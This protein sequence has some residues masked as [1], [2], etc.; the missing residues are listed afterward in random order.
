MDPKVAPKRGQD[1]QNDLEEGRK[2]GQRR[3][4]EVFG[5]TF[6]RHYTFLEMY[7]RKNTEENKGSLRDGGGPG[8]QIGA[9]WS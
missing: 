9:T 6:E 3:R 8:A 2:N 1:S 5:V 4:F 7:N